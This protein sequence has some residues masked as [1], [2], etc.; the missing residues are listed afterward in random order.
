MITAHLPAIAFSTTQRGTEANPLYQHT[1]VLVQQHSEGS[2][3]PDP[4][5]PALSRAILSRLYGPIQTEIS[6]IS[7]VIRAFVNGV[8]VGSSIANTD[9]FTRS[10]SS[11]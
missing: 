8:Q 9:T 5:K 7:G 3:S 2:L 6:R 11:A 10:T 1:A 4:N